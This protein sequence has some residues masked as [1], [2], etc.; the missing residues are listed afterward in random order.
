MYG[1]YGGGDF[2]ADGGVGNVFPAVAFGRATHTPVVP[3]L[4]APEGALVRDGGGV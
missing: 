1:K 3:D 4:R 2:D